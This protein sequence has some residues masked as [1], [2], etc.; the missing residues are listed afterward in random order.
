[1]SDMLTKLNR[2]KSTLENKKNERERLKGYQDS[3]MNQLKELGFAS[4][5]DA[6]KGLQIISKEIDKLT[7]DFN[8]QMDKF[9]SNYGEVLK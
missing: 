5:E 1:M 4:I 6:E 2:Y 7:E 3:L 9:V 8:S